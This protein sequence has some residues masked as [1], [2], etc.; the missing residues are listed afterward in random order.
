MQMPFLHWIVLVNVLFK[1]A[2]CIIITFFCL[3]MC[4]VFF[5]YILWMQ[6]NKSSYVN[7]VVVHCFVLNVLEIVST[8][9]TTTTLWHDM[10]NKAEKL[11]KIATAAETGRKKIKYCRF[12]VVYHVLSV[13]ILSHH[14]KKIGL[15]WWKMKRSIKGKGW[16]QFEKIEKQWIHLH[17]I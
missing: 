4:V 13:R 11:F 17:P 6:R 9:K 14:H 12:D 8:E 2:C 5:L 3:Y 7:G 16:I 1:Y 10:T 15:L